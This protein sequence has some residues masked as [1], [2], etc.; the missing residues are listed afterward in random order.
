MTMDEFRK[1][2][3]RRVRNIAAVG[4]D[5]LP[6]FDLYNYW[7]EGIEPDEA[8]LVANDAAMDLLAQEGFP[9]EEGDW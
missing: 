1:A 4:L 9:V 8:K 7:Y 6:D 3:D 2:V 5:D